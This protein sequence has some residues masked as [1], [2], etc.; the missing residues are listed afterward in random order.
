MKS[1]HRGHDVGNLTRKYYI[2]KGNNKIRKRYPKEETFGYL[3]L[4]LSY[5]KYFFNK[6]LYDFDYIRIC[7]ENTLQCVLL[8]I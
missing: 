5:W 2:C 6:F 3:F 1:S 7:K 8:V 4:I